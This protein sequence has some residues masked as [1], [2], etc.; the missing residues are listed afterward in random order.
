MPQNRQRLLNTDGEDEEIL[1][2]DDD[3]VPVGAESQGVNKF[4]P[5]PLKLITQVEKM[6]EEKE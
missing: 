3:E 6:K 1:E 2:G 4:L 5:E